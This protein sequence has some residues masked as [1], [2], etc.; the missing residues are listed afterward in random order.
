M[1]YFF[2]GV[3]CGF[4]STLLYANYRKRHYRIDNLT[5]VRKVENEIKLM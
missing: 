4:F 1:L 5:S 2:T 3:L